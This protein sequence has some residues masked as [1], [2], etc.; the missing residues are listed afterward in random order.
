MKIL[1]NLIFLLE[2]FLKSPDGRTD[3]R[4]VAVSV[5]TVIAATDGDRMRPRAAT[6]SD[7]M[8]VCPRIKCGAH[9]GMVARAA[10]AR[11]PPHHRRYRIG[12]V[13]KPSNK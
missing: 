3:G 12:H 2:R 6:C 8:A 5:A 9:V 11:G 4:T 7:A 10:T 13:R 1:E